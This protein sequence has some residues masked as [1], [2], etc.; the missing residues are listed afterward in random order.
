VLG[1]GG[2]RWLRSAAPTL[3]EHNTEI[4][5]QL[6]QVDP[7]TMAALEEAHVIGTRPAGL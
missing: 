6:L 7:D 3:G 1:G 2:H 5:G 4:L